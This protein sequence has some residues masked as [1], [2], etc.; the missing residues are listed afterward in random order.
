[1]VVDGKLLTVF[2]LAGAGGVSS[3]AS[4]SSV[5][6]LAACWLLSRRW[7]GKA[8]GGRPPQQ[9][10]ELDAGLGELVGLTILEPEGEQGTVLGDGGAEACQQ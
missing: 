10:C 8:L 3:S 5:D 1:M 7:A 9:V 2:A 6:P 4:P